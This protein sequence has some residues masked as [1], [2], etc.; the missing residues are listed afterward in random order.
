M[1][2]VDFV[3]EL[4]SRFGNRPK[5]VL[6][7]GC[8][9][10]R[11]ME[12]FIKAGIK[13]DGFDLSPEML[14]QAHQRMSGKDITLTEGNLT[15]FENGKKYDLIVAMFAVMGYLTENEQMLAGLRTAF[16]HLNPQG[17][18][19]FDG[20]FGPAV[21]VQQPEERCHEY[22]NKRGKVERKV[23]PHLDPVR[24]TVTMN[25]EV[26]V[27]RDGQI[28]QRISEEHIMRFM[29]IH[30]MAFAMEKVGL[31]LVY[32]CPFMEPDK[33]LT[34]ADWNVSFVAQKK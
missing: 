23:V 16:K 2:E 18:F 21:L 3:L 1:A 4:A 31:E 8:G 20:W 34:T 27:K 29:F 30:E 15:S 13:C 17:I 32:Y 7:M 25:Y 24:Q 9:T 5:T 6:D 22:E 12:K 33:G 11:H 28:I 10:G 26:T 19:V 14:V